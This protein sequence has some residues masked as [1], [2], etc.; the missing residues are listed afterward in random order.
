MEQPPQ[1]EGLPAAS[2]KSYMSHETIDSSLSS[3][4]D[5]LILATLQQVHIQYQLMNAPRH[6]GSMLGRQYIHRDREAGHWRLYN[7]YFSD[8]PS[9]GP[10]FFQR[11]FIVQDAAS[12]FSCITQAVEQHD[13]YFVRKRDR[14]GRLGLSSLQKITVAL[15]CAGHQY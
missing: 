13:D 6:G 8:S 7:D 15:H 4:D 5:E 14:T 9:Y 12:S 11:R 2:V 1:R 10:A 3:L